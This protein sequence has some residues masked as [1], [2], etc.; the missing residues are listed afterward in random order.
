MADIESLELRVVGNSQNA[1]Q[2]IESL[3]T[4]LGRLDGATQN[5]CGLSALEK[6][7][8]KLSKSL[9]TINADTTQRLTS[10][11]GALSALSQVGN[12][13]L[14]SSIANQIT[15][16][17]TAVSTQSGVDYSKL[18]D[19][20]TG[21]KPL[22]NL[23]KSNLASFV[24]QL[25]KIPEVV[26]DL[27]K[28]DMTAFAIKIREVTDTI[29]PLA[30]EM[31]KVSNGFSA[32]P[33][34]IRNFCQASASVPP[35]NKASALSFARLGAKVLTATYALRRVARVVASWIKES[36]DYVEN[37]NLFNVAMGEYAG[38]AM[39]Y[40]KQVSDLMGI[41]V[42]DWIR[43]QG[44]FMTLTTGFGVVTDRAATMSEQLTQLGYD[45]SS[46]YNIS[47]DDAMQ[48]LQSGLAG[49]L[50]PLRRLGYDLSQAKLKAT[51]L[52]LGIDKAVTSMTQAE[53]AEL[54]YYAIMTQVTQVQG[55][56]ARTLE[57]PANQLRI[58]KAQ[59]TMAARSLGNIF[60]PALNAVLPYAIAATK[61]IRYLADAIAGLF[62][63]VLPEIDYSNM[64]GLGNSA[65]DTSD[66]LGDATEQAGEL[67]KMLLGIDELNVMSDN[68]SVSDALDGSGFDFE[69]PTYDFIDE[70]VT[71]R[72]DKIVEQFKD[73]LGI[74]GDIKTW[75]DLFD[76]KLG[77]ILLTVGAIAAGFAAWKIS[78]GVLTAINAIKS[79]G[80]MSIGIPL[81]IVGLTLFMED[82][83]KLKDYLEDYVKNGSTFS[84]VSGMIS[85][86][87][88]LIGDA[89]LIL[90][91][92][93]IGGAL[94]VVQG[95]GEIVSAIADMVEEGVD[96]DNVMTMLKGLSGVAFGISL[97]TKDIKLIGTS[98]ALK[99]FLGIID[100]LGEN[101]DAIKNGD[102]SGVDKA[103]LA[104]AAIEAITGI[105]SALGV[106]N[107]IKAGANIGK[108]A[109]NLSEVAT[110]ASTV[111]KTTT[112]LTTKLST[113]AKNLGLGIAV[114]AEV[115]IAAG[116]FVGAI[117]GLGKLLEQ[118]GKAWEPVLKKGETIGAAILIGTA[119][120][121]TIGAVTAALGSAGPSICANI[122]IGI[123]VLAEIG[124]A[125]G[126]YIAEIW[127]IGWGLEKV[128]EAWE[129]VHNN[130]EN[131]E[132]A[133]LQGT[134]LLVAVATAAGLLGLATT[135]TG[136]TLPA[137]IGIGTAILAEMGIA[138]GLFIAEIWAI[139]WGLDEVGKAWGP[140]LE[141][142]ETIEEA[143]V[144]GTIWLLAVG[145]AAAA[146]GAVTTAT[147]Y[148]LPIAI[149]IGT[150][151]L[152][153]IGEA[154]KLFISE[155]SEIGKKLDKMSKAWEPVLAEGN[156]YATEI[157]VGTSLL[158]AVGS[159]AAALGGASIVSVGLLPAAV[160]LGTEMLEKLG[161][162]FRSLISEITKV[163]NRLHDDLAPALSRLNGKLP[164][165]KTDMAN[166]T[167]YMADLVGEIYEY[168]VNTAMGGFA[169][170][171]QTVISF[172]SGDPFGDLADTLE[173]QE[174][175]VEDLV[176]EL[177]YMVEIVGKAK[178]LMTQFNDAMDGLSAAAGA[179]ANR[180]GVTSYAIQIAVGLKKDGWTT[181]EKWLGGLDYKLDITMPKIGINWDTKNYLGWTISYPKSFYTYAQGGFPDVGEMFIARE[182]G[183]EL[184]GTIGNRTA[185][186]NN[187]QIVDS[188][189]KG[190]YKAVVQAM[191][192]SGGSQTVEAKVN[193][194]VLFE[195]VVNRNRQEMMRT[196]YNPMLG[197]A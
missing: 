168:S 103:T 193:D 153:E 169:K 185:V 90:G 158:T 156:S 43:N 141:N 36:N 190:V 178:E 143:I 119:I 131:I 57:A 10:L 144:Q 126:L 196:G 165:M 12:F 44:V 66:A 93:K 63:F 181:M 164:S 110:A 23:G 116:L 104:I 20:A 120:L 113:L 7:I 183:P 172:F 149:G 61:V 91:R 18:Q 78:T 60:I 87:A 108:T 142:G 49:E 21:L 138:T 86:F 188:V 5:G 159:A 186:A 17:G 59:L 95:V 102:W 16:I 34:K 24:T 39:E 88:G 124:V 177:K 31:Q 97:F 58:F 6:S 125:A 147:G 46:F 163:S 94:K 189:S 3:I 50:E 19:L 69:L 122:G 47:V 194:K 27:N 84:N 89:M 35:V 179:N 107:K 139:G 79:L 15:A 11:A 68:S 134:V 136:G 32:F 176:A 128:G 106:F 174:D 48:K 197:G 28:V 99:G 154:T 152:F 130:G 191:S 146:I 109:A 45:L 192:Q 77:D 85:E 52:S 173:D 160:N 64:E 155:I 98:L 145:A 72:V 187:D 121:V 2:S 135:A 150:G 115:A 13:K 1:I 132:A 92:I 151:V 25:K 162:A 148:T 42:S 81:T 30:D 37:L 71:S 171:V 70:A 73:W 51:A 118:V 55:D 4:T 195:V 182:A 184:V 100:E 40:A 117:W 133:I 75:A 14:S 8:G 140:V 33:S 137:A 80:G 76:T 38:S 82:L 170:S 56:M 175:G 123:G 112:T 129:P 166:F 41:D 111:A 65:G 83:E 67:K 161:R 26:N 53:K 74:T 29:K 114:I 22:E 127:A 9:N 62:G 105:V 157:A 96:F 101:W 167:D 180:A 54:R